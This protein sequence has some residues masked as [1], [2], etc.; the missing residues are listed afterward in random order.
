MAPVLIKVLFFWSLIKVV[1]T[2]R[3]GRYTSINCFC[4]NMN[5][6]VIYTLR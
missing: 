6:G 3:I 2:K 1:A 5:Y 4:K